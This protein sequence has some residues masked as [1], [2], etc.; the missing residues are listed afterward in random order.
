MDA[1]L[2]RAAEASLLEVIGFAYQRPAIRKQ[3]MQ[4]LEGAVSP[5]PPKLR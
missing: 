1:D 5:P 2:Y 3:R 4:I